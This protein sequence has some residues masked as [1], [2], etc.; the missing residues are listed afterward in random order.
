MPLISTV[1]M[2]GNPNDV[3][4]GKKL[5]SIYFSLLGKR[6]S[7]FKS[8]TDLIEYYSTDQELKAKGEPYDRWHHTNT[9]EFFGYASRVLNNPAKLKKSLLKLANMTTATKAPSSYSFGKVI[10]NEAE[11]ISLEE[12]KS[13][14]V[15]AVKEG[16]TTIVKT[17]AFGAGAYIAVIGIAALAAFLYRMKMQSAILKSLSK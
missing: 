2:A 6:P 3:N 12:V 9:L 8:L 10:A 1:G 11:K 13:S 16:A 7:P 14:V 17:A 5:L 15:T 4:E